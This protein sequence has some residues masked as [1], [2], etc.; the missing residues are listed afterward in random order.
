M[1]SQTA[2]QVLPPE[3]AERIAAGE[4]V[5]RPASVVKELI[6]NSLDAGAS[7]ISVEIRDGGLSLIRVSDDGCGISRADLPLALERF[8]TSKIRTLE[9]LEA[10]R[11]LG[12]RG[13]ALSSI[14]AV[15]HLEILTRT[16]DELEG[17]RLHAKGG[18]VVIEPAASPVGTSVTVRHLFYNTPARRKF[19]KSPMREGELVRQT[20]LR[21]SLAYPAVAFRLVVNGRETY[22]APPATPLERIGAALG[23]EVAAEMVPIGWEAADLRI[24]GYISRPTLGRRDR[25]GQFFFV[26]GRPVRSGLL[27]VML[28]RPYAGRL[29]P[30]RRPLAVVHIRLDPRLVDVNVHPRKAEVRLSQER[31]VY[32]A[33]TRAVEEA[34][35]PYPRREEEYPALAWPFAEVEVGVVREERAEYLA[36]RLEPMG[37]LN[38]AY[39]VARGPEG[40]VVVDQHAAHEQVLFER[41]LNGGPVRPLNPPVR[42]ELTSREAERL[43][44][45][46]PLL[47][48]LGMEVEPFG[49][50]T[51]LIRAL[52]AP[53]ATSDPRELLEA[54]L[55]EL[56]GCRRLE[57]EAARERLAMKMA[58]TAAVKAGDILSAEEMQALLD[59]LSAAWSPATCPHGRPAFVLLT[60]EELER[61]FMRR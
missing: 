13:E 24:E 32:G 4:V 55:E 31:S 9:D 10:I 53:V 41:L 44:P 46:L 15:A 16:R 43:E 52:P 17:S 57:P 1:V 61:R 40:L 33:L 5:E 19:L 50:R 47:A 2:I 23:R 14:A 34:L 45:F 26:N 6:E 38:N 8:A 7:A 36:V 18:E 48:D 30:E 28:E 21:Y 27:A 20:V 59:D 29:P 54:V 12:F 37:Q 39:I 56:P 60:V 51:F 58:C 35:A 11:T 25:K 3:V 49:R 22:V 42:V